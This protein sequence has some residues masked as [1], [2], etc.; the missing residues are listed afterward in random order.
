MVEHNLLGDT[1]ITL[2]DITH[3]N[4]IFG[5]SV[6]VLKDKTV[7]KVPDPVVSNYIVVLDSIMD[8]YQ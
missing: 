1:D 5:P 6:P 7:Q 2:W 8:K 4:K 3:T